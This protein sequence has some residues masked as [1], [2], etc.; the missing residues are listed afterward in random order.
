MKL[1]SACALFLLLAVPAAGENLVIFGWDGTGLGNVQ[2]LLEEGRLPNLQ[3]FV[4][5]GATLAPL[6]L[7]AR[8]NTMAGWTQIFT[9]LTYDQ[10]G[11]LGNEYVGDV[12]AP[13]DTSFDAKNG[14]FPGLN[15]WIRPVPYR[16]TI[17]SSLQV[18]GYGIGWF[19]SKGYLGMNRDKSTLAEVAWNAD[20]FLARYPG[21]QGDAYLDKLE[22][23]AVKFMSERERFVIFLH[24]DPDYYGHLLGENDPRYEGEF[25][26]AD[27]LLGRLL[28]AVDRQT[29]RFLVVS[30]HG[31]DEGQKAHRNAVDAWMAT[32]LPVH[33]AY[34]LQDG[35][36]AFATPRDVAPT[37]L[38]WYGIPWEGWTPALRGK[39]LLDLQQPGSSRG[40]G[41]QGLSA[42]DP[43]RAGAG[44]APGLPR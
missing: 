41:D 17:L 19:V 22:A 34:A 1:V 26:R 37:V 5:G 28:A 7:I 3:G 40:L 38:E 39:S 44:T 6:E 42:G 8:P 20:D 2:R 31:V 16:Q 33:A 4:E 21:V 30:D 43:Q 10:S 27:A 25:V 24:V 11:V 13:V 32:D 35:Q 12:P 29:T 36:R 9:G 18:R 14:V 15:F 23:R